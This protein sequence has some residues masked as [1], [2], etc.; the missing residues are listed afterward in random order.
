MFIPLNLFSSFFV[1]E[2]FSFNDASSISNEYVSLG[3]SFKKNGIEIELK[4]FIEYIKL[5]LE[6]VSGGEREERKRRKKE[7]KE[8]EERKKKFEKEKCKR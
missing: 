5:I 1:A 2:I 6:C 3:I 4:L 7:K 8:R